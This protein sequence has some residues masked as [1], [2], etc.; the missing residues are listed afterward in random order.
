MSDET[1]QLSRTHGLALEAL[2]AEADRLTEALLASDEADHDGA[3]QDAVALLE[4]AVKLYSGLAQ[5]RPEGTLS[6]DLK[7]TTT[8]AVTV[9]S[10]LVISQGLSLFEFNVWFARMETLAKERARQTNTLVEE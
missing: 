10:V 2:A 3:D 8:D 9:A 7:L 5:R 4:A 6:T 1:E